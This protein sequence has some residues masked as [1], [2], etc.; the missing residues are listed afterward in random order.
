MDDEHVLAVFEQLFRA[1]HEFLN[2]RTVRFIQYQDRSRII[3]RYLN[4]HATVLNTISR[5][6]SRNNTAATIFTYTMPLNETNFMDPVPVVPTQDQI[7][8]AIHD[9]TASEDSICAICQ[10]QVSSSGVQ[11]NY[12]D[13]VFHR[14]CISRWFGSSVRCPVCRHDIREHQVTETSSV[15]SQT[16][17]PGPNQ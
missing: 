10:Q 2:E 13:H 8:N 3:E 4:N 11:I 17:V 6:F 14:T 5:M 12:C 16:I 1:E 7:N 9:F 15:S